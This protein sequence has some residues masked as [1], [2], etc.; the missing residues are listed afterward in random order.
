MNNYKKDFPW[1]TKNPNLIYLDNSAT[2]LKPYSV[3]KAISMYY[4]NLST[5]PHALDSK[6]GQETNSAVNNARIN[7]ANFFSCDPNQLI[8]SPGATH[9]LNYVSHFLKQYIKENDEIIITDADHSSSSTPLI[10]LAK[11]NKAKIVIVKNN[12]NKVIEEDILRKINERTK[13]V[14]I[15]NASNTLGYYINDSLTKKIKNINPN[16]FVSI[17]AT[18][19]I[20]HKKMNFK[21]IGADFISGSAHKILGPTGIGFLF[22][23]DC[24]NTSYKPLINGG[25]AVSNYN[26]EEIYY[27]QSPEKYEAGTP[28]VAGILGF[29]EAINYINNIKMEKIEEIEQKLKLKAINEMKQIKE[30]SIVNESPDLGIICFNYS[31]LNA[32]D[33]AHYLSTKNIVARSGLSCAKMLRDSQIQCNSFVRI[34]FYFYNT[35]EDVYKLVSALRGYKKGDELIGLFD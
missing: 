11:E 16:I 24:N 33:L 8:F 1:F 12:G 35:E 10:N 3:I 20:A 32:Q 18:Q 29:S 5:N 31:G 17:D 19:A 15:M 6:I 2:T 23:K 30:I 28:N 14:S 34:S 7:I 4:E 27:S 9:S 13:V 21:E 26:N 22:I 25:G